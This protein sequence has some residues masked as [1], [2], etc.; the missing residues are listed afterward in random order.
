MAAA[1]AS[2]I[3]WSPPTRFHCWPT[4]RG[5]VEARR[6][7]R[8]HVGARDLAAL[9]CP[10]RAR[11]GR[12]LPVVGQSAGP[13]DGPVEVAGAQ[14][15]VGVA[16]GL[17]VRLPDR[18]ASSATGSS[19]LIAEIW[20][21]RRMPASPAPAIDFR[22]PSRSTVRLRSTLPSGPPPAAN[23]TASQPS[24]AAAKSVCVAR[25]RC[26]AVRVSTPVAPQRVGLLLP[27][28]QRDRLVAG[29]EQHR[30]EQAGDLSV[31]SD[32]G[33]TSHASTVRRAISRSAR[34]STSRSTGPP[35]LNSSASAATSSGS[36]RL[37]GERG[38][39]LGPRSRSR[40]TA[41]TCGATAR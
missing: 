21:K 4:V 29:V 10:A 37:A 5:V 38:V 36:A 14:R 25:S 23:T 11:P 26:R 33:D 28:D 20:T 16:L 6:H 32:D 13:Q 18:L 2:A 7:H 12:W 19:T 27:T 1:I 30:V 17:D 3:G 35:R 40:A 39:V 8:G 31:S 41:T 24:N 34:V 22:E 15:R 9:R